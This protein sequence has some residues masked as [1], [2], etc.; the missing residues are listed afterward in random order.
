MLQQLIAIKETAIYYWSPQNARAEI[1]FLIQIK[2]KIIPVEVKAAE[3]LHAKS[4]RVM[5]NLPLYAI[6]AIK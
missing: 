3:N 6:S 4:L 2:G 1:D 5:T